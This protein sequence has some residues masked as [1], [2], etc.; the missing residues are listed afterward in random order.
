[1]DALGF[2]EV[3]KGESRVKARDGAALGCKYLGPFLV[4]DGYEKKFFTRLLCTFVTG[5]M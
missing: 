1:M 4:H 3:G 2:F 5:L